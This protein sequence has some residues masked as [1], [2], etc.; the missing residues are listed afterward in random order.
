MNK[1]YQLLNEL[2]RK[3]HTFTFEDAARTSKPQ[4]KTPPSA[5]PHRGLGSQPRRYQAE[6]YQKGE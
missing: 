6:A 1:K 2:A 3:G 4:Y 5:A